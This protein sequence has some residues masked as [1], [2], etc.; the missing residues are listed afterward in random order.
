MEVNGVEAQDE[1]FL[2]PPNRWV[3]QEGE[4]N[5]PIIP[6]ELSGDG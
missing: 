2:P 5:D 3:N 4:L 6:K 1:H